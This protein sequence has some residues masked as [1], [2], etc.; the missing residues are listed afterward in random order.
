[1]T[2]MTVMTSFDLTQ[3]SGTED[4]PIT[5]R[6]ETGDREDC[7]LKGDGNARVLEIL[8]SWYIIEV[9]YIYY[10]SICM[11]FMLSMLR[12]ARSMRFDVDYL[13]CWVGVS[14]HPAPLVEMVV[15]QLGGMMIRL[16]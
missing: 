16:A 15:R 3:V 5:I 13:L 1:M 14:T 7:V 6:C 4:D 2:L 12:M 11:L 8:N 10:R 9:H